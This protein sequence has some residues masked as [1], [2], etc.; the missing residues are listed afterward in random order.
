MESQQPTHSRLHFLQMF[1]LW[2]ALIFIGT[3]L[4]CALSGQLTR[5]NYANTLFIAG[6]L[7]LGFGAMGAFSGR[8]RGDGMQ[9]YIE[10]VNTDYLRERTDQARRM[11]D[12]LGGLGIQLLVIGIV[13]IIVS[14]IL[15]VLLF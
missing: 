2:Q 6:V 13:P 3:A 11:T 7:V 8:S 12:A 9:R 10:N 4:F 1:A 5:I 14:I 15:S